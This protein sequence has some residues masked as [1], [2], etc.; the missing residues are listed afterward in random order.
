MI[1]CSAWSCSSGC[2]ETTWLKTLCIEWEKLVATPPGPPERFCATATTWRQVSRACPNG[3]V[4]SRACHT[5]CI[6]DLS[7]ATTVQCFISSAT[8]RRGLDSLS[9]FHSPLQNAHRITLEVRN[10]GLFSM[11]LRR[12]VDRLIS[13]CLGGR[14][15]IGN[16]GFSSLGVCQK[17]S[18]RHP[19]RPRTAHWGP[20]SKERQLPERSW[21][22]HISV[23]VI[24]LQHDRMALNKMCVCWQFCLIHVSI[25]WDRLLLQDTKWQQSSL[26]LARRS[27]M[28]MRSKERAMQ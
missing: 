22:S 14:K 15:C 18:S 11:H 20:E 17:D 28:W 2:Q 5:A 10:L 16:N 7:R 13:Y 25:S 21:G 4:Y 27:W 12:R 9:Q 1:R 6:N 8:Q 26:V 19:N 23:S 3:H 24:S